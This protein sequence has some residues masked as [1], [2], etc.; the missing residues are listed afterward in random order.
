MLPSR[1]V[2][3]ILGGD[4]CHFKK[5]PE[6]KLAYDLGIKR[7]FKKGLVGPFSKGISYEAFSDIRELCRNPFDA[8]FPGERTYFD[9]LDDFRME[10][11]P[12]A[13]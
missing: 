3:V 10:T 6:L 13:H 7:F 1:T 4:L 12:A 11:I 5:H 8:R 2:G 9:G